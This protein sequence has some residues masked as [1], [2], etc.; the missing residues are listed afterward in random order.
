[1]EPKSTPPKFED[2]YRR[3]E[4]APLLTLAMTVADWIKKH[5][6]D[7]LAKQSIAGIDDSSREG[8]SFR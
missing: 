1:M 5:R 4:F 2:V 7:R 6:A 8:H 3:Y